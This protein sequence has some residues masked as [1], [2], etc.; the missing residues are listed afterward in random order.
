LKTDRKEKA[1]TGSETVNTKAMSLL[2]QFITNPL[3]EATYRMDKTN[4]LFDCSGDKILAKN[5]ADLAETAK[6]AIHVLAEEGFMYCGD[7]G[8]TNYGTKN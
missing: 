4:L 5:I 1:R 2:V 7:S 3:V 8:Q 6:R